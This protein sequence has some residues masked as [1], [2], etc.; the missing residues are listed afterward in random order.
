MGF[1]SLKSLLV[2]WGGGYWKTSNL[3]CGV[4]GKIVVDSG[5]DND[6]FS[7]I[8]GGTSDEDNDLVAFFLFL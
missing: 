8:G 4:L 2:R 6:E 7:I 1:D 5:T 3:S